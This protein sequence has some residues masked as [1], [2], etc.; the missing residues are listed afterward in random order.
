VL[1]GVF[2][3][4]SVAN[5]HAFDMGKEGVLATPAILKKIGVVALGAAREKAALRRASRRSCGA[6]GKSG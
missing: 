2:D 3:A 4:V 6:A 5:N 1:R